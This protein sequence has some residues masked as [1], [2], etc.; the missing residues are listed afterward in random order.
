M[1]LSVT[2]TGRDRTNPQAD[3]KLNELMPAIVYVGGK[4]QVLESYRSFKDLGQ[5]DEI[6]PAALVT[7]GR[8]V[9]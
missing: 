6:S 4:D 3:P 2:A 9:R 1:D 5:G 8:N 7:R